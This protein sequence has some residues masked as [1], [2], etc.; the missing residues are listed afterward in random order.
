MGFRDQVSLH[1]L[2]RPRIS[3]PQS[4]SFPL[5]CASTFLLDSYEF[6]KGLHSSFATL[7]GFHFPGIFSPSVHLAASAVVEVTRPG[8][9][10]VQDMS[11]YSSRTPYSPLQ[12][13]TFF[14]EVELGRTADPSCCAFYPNCRSSPCSLE[15][16]H[17]RAH[18]PLVRSFSK[19]FRAWSSSLT[20]PHFHSSPPDDVGPGG[21]G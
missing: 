6:L 7:H 11:P 12:G 9:G 18:R 15:V 8:C 16:R 1:D 14:S 2:L 19:T 4:S 20:T 17:D 10:A 13:Q 21:K 5:H 3:F